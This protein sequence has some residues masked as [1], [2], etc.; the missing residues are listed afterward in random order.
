MAARSCAEG[1]RAVVQDRGVGLSGQDRRGPDAV[2]AVGGVQV[3]HEVV[4]AR[5]R[6]AVGGAAEEVGP[7]CRQRRHRDHGA[8]AAVEHV[9]QHRPGEGEHGGEVDPE[10]LVPLV[11]GQPAGVERLR[12][13]AGHVDQ[14]VHRPHSFAHA[15][16]QRGDL[17]R[18]V[19]RGRG[20]VGGSARRGDGRRHLVEH[21]PAPP[22]EHGDRAVGGQGE[23]G[24]PPDAAARAGDQ[25][26]LALQLTHQPSQ[27]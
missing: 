26:D 18:V 5:L 19:D 2:V 9:R 22:D 23:R 17:D 1:G 4:H 3:A 11:V 27:P 14:H 25:A 7:Q 13:R 12:R 8:G 15:V 6:G 21:L 10:R 20:D 16:D 24:G